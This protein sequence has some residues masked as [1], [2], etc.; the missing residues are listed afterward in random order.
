MIGYPGIHFNHVPNGFDYSENVKC[1]FEHGTTYGPTPIQE[2]NTSIPKT[3]LTRHCVQNLKRQ[4]D[5]E[6]DWHTRKT[7]EACYNLDGHSVLN[8]KL[9]TT[10]TNVMNS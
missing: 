7:L 3:R 8:Y 6:T 10:Y 2:S 9:H 4:P 1:E 5:F